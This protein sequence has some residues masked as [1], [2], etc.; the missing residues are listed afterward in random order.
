MQCEN[1]TN[2]DEMPGRNGSTSPGYQA[3]KEFPG[4]EYFIPIYSRSSVLK[5]SKDFRLVA[6]MQYFSLKDEREKDQ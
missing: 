5:K 3:Y 4:M 6:F 1:F 2:H